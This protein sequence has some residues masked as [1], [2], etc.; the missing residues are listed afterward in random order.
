MLTKIQ[1]DMLADDAKAKINQ[2]VADAGVGSPFVFDP[3]TVNGV[4]T[5]TLTG[6]KVIDN[7]TTT[8]ESVR[9]TEIANDKLVVTLATFTPGLTAAATPGASLN[10]DV[11]A[12]GFTA[13]VDNPYDYTSKWIS[14]VLAVA[15]L[16]GSSVSA[17]LADY[18]AGAYSATP[19]GGVDW[20]RTFSTGG[21]SYIRSASTTSAG[22][23]ASGRLTFNYSDGTAHAYTDNGA[24]THADFA[25][26]WATPTHSI[27]ISLD[28]PGKTF[29]KTYTTASYTPS[30]TGIADSNNR[31][32]TISS[33]SGDI[34]ETATAGVLTFATPI[35]KGNTGTARKVSLVT[36][37]RRPQAVTGSA[38]NVDLASVDSGN[39][40]ASATFSYP[41]FWTWT[42]GTATT[43]ALGDCVTDATATGFDAT[44]NILGDQ[45]K[46]FAATV[47]NTD[48]NPRAFW[49]AIKASASQ[50]S[51]FKTGVDS[52]LMSA[53]NYVTSTISL[54][55]ETN[56][57]NISETYNLYGFVLQP[58]NTY[59]SIS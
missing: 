23:S 22:G 33:T 15:A 49:F 32:F 4:T 5:E 19:A 34:S 12:T 7:G 48:S 58:G 46:T 55:P 26:T 29:L 2:Q 43:P 24:T 31:T 53:V 38:Y 45:A 44:V 8:V 36:N 14:S 16:N 10:W 40:S 28:N 9:K 6:Y 37:I 35:H 41:S 59:V 17:V 21:S 50:P 30:V 57:Y 39:V 13:T 52:S 42:C 1:Y 51:N 25:V 54:H 47:N 27:N 18:S 3:H 56:P 20:T 11:A